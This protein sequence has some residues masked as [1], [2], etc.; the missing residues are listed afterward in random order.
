MPTHH[1]DVFPLEIAQAASLFLT[2][3]FGYLCFVLQLLEP[4]CHSARSVESQVSSIYDRI[5]M[6]EG[7][8][9]EQLMMW[10]S[11]VC[12]QTQNQTHVHGS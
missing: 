10:E 3:I 12:N 8:A 11:A 2:R 9:E 1:S 6:E 5:F 7:A 4:R